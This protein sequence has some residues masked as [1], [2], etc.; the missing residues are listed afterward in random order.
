MLDAV[1]IAN[2]QIVQNLS[3]GIV[4]LDLAHKIQG[5]NPAAARILGLE[6]K[7]I[8]NHPLPELL[9]SQAHLLEI[10]KASLSK[11]PEQDVKSTITV[12]L[13]GGTFQLLISGI[14]NLI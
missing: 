8:P 10:V 6:G 11:P 3:V 13:S 7:K 2:D 5:I 4:V 14:Q 12:K 1:S 9:A